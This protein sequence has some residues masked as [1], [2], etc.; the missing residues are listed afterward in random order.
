MC[1]RDRPYTMQT[2]VSRF[3]PMQMQPQSAVTAQTWT[4]KFPTSSVSLYS[5]LRKSPDKL[6]TITP[7]WS[8]TLPSDYNYATPA[9]FPSDNGGWYN[10]KDRQTLSARKVNLKRN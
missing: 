5:T 10:P 9:P 7:G 6:T 1:I 4:R 3:A 8:Y 2:G